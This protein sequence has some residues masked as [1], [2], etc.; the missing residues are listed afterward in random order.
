MPSPFPG[1]DPYLE[2]AEVWQDFHHALAEEVKRTLN[3][4][5]GPKYY[6][7]VETQSVPR[8]LD[9]EIS[10]R[11]RPDVS[12]FE[13]LDTAPGPLSATPTAVTVPPAPIVWPTPLSIKLR[14]VRIYHTQTSVLVT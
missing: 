4:R 5:I 2:D 6:A 14:A 7:A 12:V 10:S 8:D 1:M 13:P 3:R 9:V 11:V